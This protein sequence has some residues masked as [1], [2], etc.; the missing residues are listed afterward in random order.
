[1]EFKDIYSKQQAFFNSNQTKD[2]GFRIEQLRKFKS[3]LKANES[4]LY[5][6]IYEDFGKSEDSQYEAALDVLLNQ[7]EA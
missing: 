3:I 6:A 2:I 1:M 7:I 4:L 5:D